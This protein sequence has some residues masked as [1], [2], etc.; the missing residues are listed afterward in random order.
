ML[1]AAVLCAI[2]SVPMSDGRRRI[3]ALALALALSGLWWG[4]ARLDALDRSVLVPRIGEVG[5]ALVEITG[6]AR[7]TPFRLRA[8]A[9]SCAFGDSSF[10]KLCCSN[11]R[12][13]ARHH[14]APSS[15]ASSSCAGR[16]DQRRLRRA[17]PAA[18]PRRP[19][20]R[21]RE[22]W[23][24]VGRRG[25]VGGVA[26]RI[27]HGLAGAIAPG[28]TG[29]RRAVLVGLV[30][31]E[32]EGLT[33]ELRAR[34]RASG[35]Y[36]LLA[37]SGQNV[38]FVVGGVLFVAWLLGISRLVAQV[39]ALGAIGAYVLAVG[40]QPSVVRAGVAGACLAGV[41]RLP[42]GGSLVLP[43][44]R[45]R[46]A[47]GVEPVQP[48][49]AR[50]PALLRRR[51]GDLRCRPAPRAGAR[52]LPGPA[53]ARRR[54]RGVGSVRARNCPD[55]P[56][57]VRL[58]T[59]LLDPEQR[60][61]R[62]RRRALLRPRSPHRPARTGRAGCRSRRRVDQ[63]LARDIAGCARIVGGLPGAGSTRSSLSEERR[64]SRSSSSPP[65]ACR[66]GVGRD[67]SLSSGYRPCS[68]SAG[69]SG[70][71]TLPRRQQACG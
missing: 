45:R 44:P 38:A 58:G 29:E 32:E 2:A 40:W 14:R 1:L 56:V 25:G 21:A 23:R 57:P 59:R 11:Y 6:P 54:R 46:G 65:C 36:H 68:W 34:F 19:R 5:P 28:L 9:E 51:R 20:R 43:L 33:D 17:R 12:S 22:S 42:A 26:D 52:G 4:G 39:A 50:V 16:A 61:R 49:G 10:A 15:R 70:R 3:G 69:S 18:P 66:L 35:L 47:S 64:S 53:A 55:P 62:D 71:A 37:V 13:D 63:R 41:A 67:S 31:G 7:R 8:G 30:L 27:H 48:A 60:A 24:P